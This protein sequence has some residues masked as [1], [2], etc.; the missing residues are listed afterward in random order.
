MKVRNR[1]PSLIF[2]YPQCTHVYNVYRVLKN[3]C[4]QTVMP[5]CWRRLLRAPWTARR[6]NQ[7]I[8]KKISPEYSL[9]GLMLKLQYFGHLMWRA[10]SLEKTLML[11][12]I[13]GK[14]RRGWQRKMVRVHHWSKGHENLSKLPEIVKDR[15]AWCAAVRGVAKSWTQLSDWATTAN[16]CVC[17]YLFCLFPSFSSQLHHTEQ[18]RTWI[19]W[20]TI[21]RTINETCCYL[22]TQLADFQKTMFHSPLEQSV[23][24]HLPLR[25][26]W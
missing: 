20:A 17:T 19:G 3:W 7:L 21:F 15:R 1:M 6:S 11:E 4:F 13:E 12:K 16:N 24:G 22:A 25:G 5:L 18:I 8:L 9:E 2:A 10:D 26:S 23:H 14:R